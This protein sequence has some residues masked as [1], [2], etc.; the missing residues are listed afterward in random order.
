MTFL[1]PALVG[2]QLALPEIR[3]FGPSCESSGGL[4]IRQMVQPAVPRD[5][6]ARRHP[7]SGG[8]VSCSRW[9]T[10]HFGS[11]LECI[12]LM[13]VAAEDGES[14]QVVCAVGSADLELEFAW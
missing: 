11:C 10:V 2:P 9:G 14:M 12:Y 5:P 3:P 13:R 4:T 6:E 8:R 1:V 7:V